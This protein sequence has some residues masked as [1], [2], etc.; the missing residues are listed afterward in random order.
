MSA[1]LSN[2]ITEN[3]VVP[4]KLLDKYKRH[5]RK[6]SYKFTDFL[7]GEY[8]RITVPFKVIEETPEEILHGMEDYREVVRFLRGNDY[9]VVDYAAG[10]CAF[11]Q[12]RKR[13]LKIGKVLSRLKAPDS[14]MTMFVNGP[15]R[16]AS[17]KKNIDMVVTIS[18]NVEDI[19]SMS[20]GRGWTSCMDAQNGINSRY[21]KKDL[22]KGT[23]IAY[24]HEKTDEDILRP[25]GRVL[26]KPFTRLSPK[27]R[28]VNKILIPER[29]IYGTTIEGFH[30]FVEKWAGDS[31]AT[32]YD[33]A[34][35]IDD[36]LYN[37]SNQ[38]TRFFVP[39]NGKTKMHLNPNER[40][41]ICFVTASGLTAENAVKFAYDASKHVRYHVVRHRS[42]AYSKWLWHFA[43]DNDVGVLANILDYT[44]D[45]E[46]I[47]HLYERNKEQYSLYNMFLGCQ[48]TPKSIR[49]EIIENIHKVDQQHLAE[50]GRRITFDEFLKIKCLT[51]YT[52]YRVAYEQILHRNIDRKKFKAL[53]DHISE[54]AKRLVMYRL[55]ERGTESAGKY[56]FANGD[57]FTKIIA[58]TYAHPRTREE[59]VKKLPKEFFGNKRKTAAAIKDFIENL[60]GGRLDSFFEDCIQKLYMW[61]KNIDTMDKPINTFDLADCLDTVPNGKYILTVTP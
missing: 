33:T 25:M 3:R 34:Y 5:V 58:I 19:V 57:I 44:N 59:Y 9:V 35:H 28:R 31:F 37:D 29:R 43:D 14:I 13:I 32:K 23:H 54:P 61:S 47:R 17:K 30:E 6:D 55:A 49:R 41:R 36:G 51:N 16:Q 60:N 42:I 24:L 7:F 46:L 8:E 27:N 2:A 4:K 15:A 22:N 1:I 20:F 11:I 21:I 18:R 50:C 26:L 38:G 39:M 52:E 40:D 56:A 12:D 45:Q 48:F 53:F 10:L